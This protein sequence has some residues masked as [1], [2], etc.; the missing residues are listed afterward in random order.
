[1]S[2][3]K[4][5]QIIVSMSRTDIDSLRLLPYMKQFSSQQDMCQLVTYGQMYIT[6]SGNSLHVM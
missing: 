2:T 5:T 4:N 1:M 6:K 3:V